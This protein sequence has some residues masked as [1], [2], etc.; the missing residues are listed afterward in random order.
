MHNVRCSQAAWLPQQQVLSFS[1]SRDTSTRSHETVSS[2][3]REIGNAM[4]LTRSRIWG[5]HHLPKPSVHEKS[6]SK[7]K[8]ACT[9]NTARELI[10]RSCII[11][12]EMTRHFERCAHQP[13]IERSCCN[14]PQFGVFFVCLP[15]FVGRTLTNKREDGTLSDDV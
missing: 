4:K 7:T 8:F 6:S 12:A 14:I 9:V 15:N 11:P 3:D 10:T 5:Q 1:C 2:S 13:K